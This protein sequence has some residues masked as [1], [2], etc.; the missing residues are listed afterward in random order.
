[1]S[2]AGAIA[3]K[4]SKGTIRR[5]TETINTDGSSGSSW[6]SVATNVKAL[7]EHQGAAIAQRLWGQET[8]VTMVARFDRSADIVERDIYVV[9]SGPQSGRRYRV[10]KLAD[11]HL[12]GSAHLEAGLVLAHTTEGV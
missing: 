8:E 2:I 3:T 5:L 10:V 9:T 1:M 11:H 7:L 6:A 4:G 12:S